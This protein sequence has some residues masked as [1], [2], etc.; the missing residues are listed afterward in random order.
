MNY[1]T[2]EAN[3]DG[4]DLPVVI[5]YDKGMAESAWTEAL[6]DVNDDVLWIND[7]CQD[8]P[9]VEG[10]IVKD[11]HSHSRLKQYFSFLNQ[12]KIL[13][14]SIR[15]LLIS[16]LLGESFSIIRFH[17][18]ITGKS[19][20]TVLRD[21]MHK[22]FSLVGLYNEKRRLYSISIVEDLCFDAKVL[23]PET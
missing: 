19:R 8:I 2:R 18:K 4:Q 10:W 23:K 14:N 20:R 21:I 12:F 9:S 1:F 11:W 17:N 5:V 3:G 6:K 15:F 22:I 16:L 7:L 13:C